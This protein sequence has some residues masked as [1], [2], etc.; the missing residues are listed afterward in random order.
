MTT[1]SSI[2]LDAHCDNF[3]AEQ[4]NAGCYSSASDV[5]RAGLHL[6]EAQQ[7][8]LKALRL[9]L[10]EGEASGIAE[11]F[12]FADFIEFR[13]LQLQSQNNP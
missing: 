11:D 10:A 9:A 2:A 8:Q 12:D 7:A 13:R 3:V 6:L 4:L 1:Q 5:V